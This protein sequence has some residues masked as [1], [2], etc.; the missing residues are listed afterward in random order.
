MSP[1]PL[2]VDR[3]FTI[4]AAQLACSD[5]YPA[6][7]ENAL[8]QNGLIRFDARLHGDAAKRV[9]FYGPYIRVEPG[10]YL[11][12]PKGEL[13]G[14]LLLRFTHSIGTLIKEVTIDSFRPIVLTLTR[15]LD[16]FEVVG[17]RTPELKSM[18][19]QSIA[20]HHIDPTP[21]A[22]GSALLC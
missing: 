5:A 16:K 9:I 18:K 20:V 2:A 17:L 8:R 11:F 10:V 21:G 22:P 13:D 19:L 15:G 1:Q 4:N 6:D 3:W 12:T 7:G 14:N